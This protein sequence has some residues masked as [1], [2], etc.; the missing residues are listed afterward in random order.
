MSYFLKRFLKDSRRRLN[1]IIIAI[2]LARVT[3]LVG[4]AG[5]LAILAA[6]AFGWT[7]AALDIWLILIAGGGL[8]GLVVGW[9]HRLDTGATARWVDE[10]HG[11]GEAYSAALVCLKRNCSGSLDELVVERAEAMA[12]D[13]KLIRWPTRYLIRQAAITGGLLVGALAVVL[14]NPPPA[15]NLSRFIIPKPASDIVSG[16]PR[17]AMN[18]LERRRAARELA[19][20]FFPKNVKR[21]MEFQKVLESGD[22]NQLEALFKQARLGY[23]ERIAQ[24]ASPSEQE[25]LLDEQEQL[26]Q[27]M[28]SLLDNIKNRNRDQLAQGGSNDTGGDETNRPAGR[29]NLKEHP[30]KPGSTANKNNRFTNYPGGKNQTFY[31]YIWKNANP[32]G[33]V[34]S[35]QKGVLKKAGM[36]PGQEPGNKQG[37]WRIT[38]HSGTKELMVNQKL[39]F[40]DMEYILPGKDATVPLAEVLPDFQRSAEAALTRNGVPSEYDEFVRIYFLELSREIKGNS[41][42]SEGQK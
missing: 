8:V 11:N 40:P 39:E 32:D 6:R 13:P 25:R 38:A 21:A 1:R 20:Q 9:R 36:E 29:N 41:P 15:W 2:H 12:G 16:N 30:A 4:A 17:R 24:S 35:P 28:R 22:T 5:A 23:E 27:K 31:Q 33:K 19:L 3:G 7:A 10:Y 18:R 37:K 34:E 26:M 42:E 14:W